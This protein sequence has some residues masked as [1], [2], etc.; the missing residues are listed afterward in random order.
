MK[1]FLLVVFMCHAQSPGLL[2]QQVK[3]ENHPGRL[4]ESKEECFTES[5]KYVEDFFQKNKD[6]VY[7]GHH[8]V[9]DERGESL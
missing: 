1:A 8:C 4:S 3:V 6:L 2:C 9:K 5:K 7:R